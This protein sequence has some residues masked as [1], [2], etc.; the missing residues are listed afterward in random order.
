M[1]RFKSYLHDNIASEPVNLDEKRNKLENK[2]A[3]LEQWIEEFE[4]KN[5][6]P[7]TLPSYE[8]YLSKCRTLAALNQQLATMMQDQKKIGLD[9]EYI[10][11]A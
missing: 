3:A 9:L 5:K 7:E 11:C 6:S 4:G 1:F 8:L 10:K 2:I